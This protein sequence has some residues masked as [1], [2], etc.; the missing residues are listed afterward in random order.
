[1]VDVS[2]VQV[3]VG[4]SGV[5]G[6]SVTTLY[7]TGTPLSL[8]TAWST[9]LNAIKGNT[10]LA[11]T[12]QFPSAGEVID[13]DTGKPTTSWTATPPGPIT[14]GD[15]GVFA[16]GVGERIVWGTDVFHNGRNIRGSTFLVPMG[17]G[18]FSANGNLNNTVRAAHETAARA[19]VTAMAGAFCILTRK[20]DTN[21]IGGIAAVKN[22]TIPNNVSWL[23]SRRV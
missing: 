21:P 13:S 2:R 15:A 18:T 19:F 10:P 4:G 8:M 12:W 7:T 11:I 20:S 1:M 16:Q 3:T 23:R 14:G 22:A 9:F 17:A 5:V 6:P